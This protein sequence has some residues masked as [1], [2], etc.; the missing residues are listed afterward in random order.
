MAPTVWVTVTPLPRRFELSAT[1]DVV[2]PTQRP[3]HL[4]ALTHK[5]PA[6]QVLDQLQEG[7]MCL[8]LRELCD[9]GELFDILVEEPDG[10]SPADALKWFVQLVDAV[11]FCHEVCAR[12]P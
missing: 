5:T 8:E 11:A 3:F 2:R 4:V 1:S 9:G 12:E 7:D 6:L 10:C